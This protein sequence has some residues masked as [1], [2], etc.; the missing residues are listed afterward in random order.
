M[1]PL[2]AG[3]L[4]GIVGVEEAGKGYGSSTIFLILGGCLLG[5][6]SSA[7]VSTVALPTRSSRLRGTSARSLVFGVMAATAFVSMWVSNTSTTLMMLPVAHV[8]RRAGR[9]RAR[10]GHRS[11]RRN[12]STAIVV[13]RRV[14]RDDRRARHADR[15]ADQRACRRPSSRRTT[16]SGSALRTG[17]VVGLPCVLLLLPLGWWIL[18]ATRIRSRSRTSR[19]RGQSSG[20]SCMS[21]RP[22]GAARSGLRVIGRQPRSPGS[23][24]R[25]CVSCRG[26]PASPTWASRCSPGSR[27]SSCRPEAAQPGT[28]LE[29]RDLRRVPWD[30][31][32]LFG[33]GLALAALI[34][35]SGLSH[36]HWPAGSAH[37]AGW[38]RHG[39]SRCVVVLV[40]VFW[41][42]LS[43]N[44]ATAA[45]FMP[46]LAALAMA[47][48]IPLL[49]LSYR[50]PWPRPAASC[51]RS[52][53]PR[54]RSSTARVGSACGI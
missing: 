41:T 37:F 14:C 26:W 6:R 11:T 54:T 42:E 45:T 44:V 49:Q 39:C 34:Q 15:H 24:R 52:A 25:G 17:C 8:D 1:L 48:G 23:R 51:C 50:R 33:G 2:A 20:A 36:Q 47:A 43:S 9:A 28:L 38:P 10:C 22:A 3:P 46:I 21:P 13:G 53:P 16:P 27:S 4:L 18:V 32:F 35:D 31:L 7:G 30:T 40:L 12:F 19:R 5:S 29:A